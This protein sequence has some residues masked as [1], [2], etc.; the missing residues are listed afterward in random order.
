MGG[1][2]GWMRWAGGW[3]GWG[4]AC[5]VGEG[6]DGAV[7]DTL[8]AGDSDLGHDEH[9]VRVRARVRVRGRVRVR[10]GVANPNPNPTPSTPMTK[11][12]A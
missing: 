11:V 10:L 12:K 3:D 4:A 2:A 5:L 1:V 6:G 7:D 9:L 8:E